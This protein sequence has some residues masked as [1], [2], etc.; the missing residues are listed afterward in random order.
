MDGR[1]FCDMICAKFIKLLSEH[2]LTDYV[3]H[4]NVLRLVALIEAIPTGIYLVIIKGG[5]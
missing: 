3:D 5:D 2:S 1:S 4:S